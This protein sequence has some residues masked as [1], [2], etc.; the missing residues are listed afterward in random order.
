MDNGWFPLLY[1]CER[2]HYPSGP[3]I[4]MARG[5]QLQMRS[6]N[7]TK[8]LTGAPLNRQEYEEDIEDSLE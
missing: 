1:E 2:R 3:V 8:G 4:T 5:W 6:L 7:H